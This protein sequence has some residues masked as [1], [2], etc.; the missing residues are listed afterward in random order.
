MK[1]LIVLV[2]LAMAVIFPTSTFALDD[3]YEQNGD[4]F[5]LI[6]DGPVRGVYKLNNLVAGSAPGYLYD[7]GKA[8]NLSASMLYNETI[9]STKKELWTFSSDGTTGM[10]FS[11]YPLIRKCLTSVSVT[12]D[13]PYDA[14]LHDQIMHIH[15][16]Y[17]GNTGSGVGI[18][19]N[20][21]YPSQ[22][23]T[24]YGY[25]GDCYPCSWMPA[26]APGKPGYYQIANGRWYHSG[27]SADQINSS[28]TY[29]RP[30]W[31]GTSNPNTILGPYKMYGFVQCMDG[32]G[33][34]FRAGLC[35]KLVRETVQINEE[36]LKLLSY[37]V[38]EKLGP[39][40]RG[41]A[42]SVVLG[43]TNTKDTLNEC[44]DP[45]APGTGPG[46]PIPTGNTPILSCL[47]SGAGRSYLYTR[48]YG[49][50]NYS[51]KLNN[52]AYTSAT[53]GDPADLTAV[54]VGVS[55]KNL[56]TDWVY[57]LGTNKINQW[58]A[59]ANVPASGFLK[60]LTDVAVSDQWWQTGGIV[61]A[62]DKTIPLVY[63]FVR[64]ENDA[65]P[66]IPEVIDI[67]SI[68]DLP[69]SIDADG[70]GN[71]YFVSTKR[72]PENQPGKDMPAFKAADA[73]TY[74]KKSTM[75]PDLY[76][77]KFKQDI[78]KGVTMLNYYSGSFMDTSG[79]ILLG[80][81][82]FEQDF[83][84]AAALLG[85]RSNWSMCPGTLV[86]TTP[87]VSDAYRTEVAVINVCTPPKVTGTTANIDI[88][89]P[90]DKDMND[91]PTPY[92]DATQY[93]FAVENAPDFDNNGVNRAGEA[94]DDPN[95]N[96]FIGRF[97]STTESA[98][99]YYY[100]KVVQT[101]NMYG[102]PLDNTILDGN[103]STKE[104]VLPIMFGPGEY[105][106]SVKSTFKYYQYD[107]MPRGVLADKKGDYL[108]ESILAKAKDNTEWAKTKIFVQTYTNPSYPGGSC[109]IMSGKPDSS[110]VSNYNYRPAL[111]SGNTNSESALEKANPSNPVGESFVIP[112]IKGSQTW[113]FQ[114]RENLAN[115]SAGIDRIT[116]MLQA[117]PP[118]PDEPHNNLRWLTD[119][120][121][122]TW[123]ISLED[124]YDATKSLVNITKETNVAKLS[125][126]AGDS[127]FTIPS[128]P[129]HYVLRVDASRV[130]SYEYFEKVYKTL[131]NGSVITIPVEKTKFVP[132][133][134]GAQCRVS[135]LDDTPPAQTLADLANTMQTA[136]DLA[137]AYL[138][139]TTG[140]RLS[141]TADGK[142]NPTNIVLW[143]ANDN[144]YGNLS[145]HPNLTPLLVDKY[146]SIS[147]KHSIAK[148]TGKFQHNN[149]EGINVPDGLPIA[150]RTA[151]QSKYRN[152]PDGLTN[153]SPYKVE[154]Y[155]YSFK[156]L[157]AD[158]PLPKVRS[159]TYRKFIIAVSDLDYFKQDG[160]NMYPEMAYHYANQ[161]ST[162]EN[163]KYGFNLVDASG[164]AGGDFMEGQIVIID[165]D[166]PLAFIQAKDDKNPDQLMVGPSN[167]QPT[168]VDGQWACLAEK[169]GQ[170]EERNGVEQWAFQ[171]VTDP[172]SIFGVDSKFKISATLPFAAV[173]AQKST[174]DPST[175]EI[176]VPVT[177]ETKLSDNVGNVSIE[178]W[179]LRD[180]DSA[181]IKDIGAL[182]KYM[183]IFRIAEN[184]VMELKVKDDA[185]NWPTNPD[186]PKN[187]TSN[188]NVRYL[189]IIIPISSSRL[190]IRTIDKTFK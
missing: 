5:L 137:P 35:H 99:L 141:N 153:K 54:K 76:R 77:A 56:T 142:S 106:I 128:E 184:Y 189:K 14:G 167:V 149:A 188:P 51:L 179:D 87:K 24:G 74:Y 147:L 13:G 140:E 156:D 65:K 143:S 103:T 139:G 105:E 162:Y 81:D 113:S 36:K 73:Y 183:H 132:I 172:G 96:S 19:D 176:D 186:N 154:Q 70:F 50:P 80:S 121:K 30:D 175:L 6:G 164:N 98:H 94:T 75:V 155:L 150:F 60:E 46:T 78:Y 112:Q 151:A 145:T 15:H 44:G 27:D 119:T 104:P 45:C 17:P 185:R 102:D 34:P 42:G 144:P 161:L 135:V 69:N 187:A 117:T 130:Y 109:V 116:A 138:W 20:K 101:K 48:D 26:A 148:S 16:N 1:K 115:K 131:S 37:S 111:I 174:H 38:D 55:S 170:S 114:A 29:L 3:F 90:Y 82:Y 97:P 124:P 28:F 118:I 92:N 8:F 57:V 47:V 180:K 91:S 107:K 123:K 49:T 59:L 181:L 22:Y 108:S 125:I 66:C 120:P 122:F 7:G 62:Y 41:Q 43:S 160:A 52:I 177:F 58:L 12:P 67:T 63:S 86:R 158:C 190:D 127:V 95:G 11:P 53:I 93:F 32:A 134:I 31:Y 100:W 39:Y 88:N 84:C 89:G 23:T 2:V 152:T 21:S 171:S 33:F 72:D 4:A 79:D 40:D 157:P 110:L 173:L 83:I 126:A 61:Y 136:I 64:N 169:T 163:L 165:N 166:R 159:W 146:F 10:H 9:K 85:D 168:Y 182:T 25:Y 18:H 71:L 129:G 178:T 68:P 133:T